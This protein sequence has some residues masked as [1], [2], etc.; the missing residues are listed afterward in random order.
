[1]LDNNRYHCP[2]CGFKGFDKKAYKDMPEMP[3]PLDENIKPPYENIWGEPSF[4][5]CSCCSFE[6]GNCDHELFGAQSFSTL[7]REWFVEG[8][9]TWFDP[10]EKP[11]HWDLIKQLEETGIPVPSYIRTAYML[12]K[13]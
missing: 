7:L 13:K 6:P 1:M 5:V 8:N 4:D 10:S 9:A 12:T 2:V 3:Y 11:D